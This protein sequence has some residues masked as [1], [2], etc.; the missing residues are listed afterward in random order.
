P[1]SSR[2]SAGPTRCA[3]PEPSPVQPLSSA[4][5]PRRWITASAVLAAGD[6]ATYGPPR[7]GAI[8]AGIGH[9]SGQLRRGG[10]GMRWYLTLLLAA[11]LLP[12]AILAAMG[13]SISLATATAWSVSLLVS[14][15]LG[16]AV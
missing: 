14:I 4:S 11:A 7:L 9:V 5:A 3:R 8:F 16:L 2:A 13:P 6:D 15:V 10:I 1:R 12:P